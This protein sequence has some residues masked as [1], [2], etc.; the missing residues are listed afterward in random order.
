MNLP[1]IHPREE[2]VKKAELKI[3]EVFL[4][5]T[6]GLTTGEVLRVCAS[7]FGSQV[8]T[9][10]KYAIRRERHGNSD[11]PGG[12]APENEGGANENADRAGHGS[13]ESPD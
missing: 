12:W 3:Q 4:E 1:R 5:V 2:L 13:D 10:A 6:E 9:I 8:G 11:R 7:V